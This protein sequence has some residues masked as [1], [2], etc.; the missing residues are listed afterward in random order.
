MIE[1]CSTR[2]GEGFRGLGHFVTITVMV[3]LCVIEPLVAVTVIV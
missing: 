2:R 3:I 1:W